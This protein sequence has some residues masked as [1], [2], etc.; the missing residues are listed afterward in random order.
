[1][2][3]KLTFGINMSVNLY[4]EFKIIIFHLIFHHFSHNVLSPSLA[5]P[6]FLD[7]SNLCVFY[8]ILYVLYH[9]LL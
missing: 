7:F 4:I 9:F 1:M 5:K 2:F 3:E 8:A 6:W